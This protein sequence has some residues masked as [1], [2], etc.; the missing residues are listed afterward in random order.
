MLEN[1]PSLSPRER[2]DRVR[3]IRSQNVGP[4]TFRQLLERYGSASSALE[5]LPE[6]AR[7]GGLRKPLCLCSA[8]TAAREMDAVAQLGGQLIVIGEPDYP[9]PLAAIAD[10]PPVLSV[11]GDVNLLSRTTIGVVGARN[12]S[13]NGRRFA[14][15]LARDLSKAGVLV[16]SGLA[17]GIDTAV[18]TG[19]L[20]GGTVAVLAGGVD[21]IYPK[22]NTSLYEAIRDRGVIVSEMPPGTEPMARH[23]PSR[24]RIISGLSLGIVVVEAALRSGSLITARLAGEQGREV[25][26]IPGSPLDP[27]ARG[28]NNLIRNGAT[29]T[30]SAEDVLEGIRAMH[31]QQLGEPKQD[32]FGIQPVSDEDHLATARTMI[33]ECLGPTPV[34]I[35]AI[36]RDT[37]LPVGTV[38][39]VLLELELAGR[40]ERQP[41]GKVALLL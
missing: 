38:W 15:N 30:E 39:T 17:R 14:E 31:E 4:V 25:F 18:H 33:L 28:A 11:L 32:D 27:R 20:E 36:L 6:L 41:G 12:A 19:A 9:L 10:A 5:A 7:Q 24:N 37:G 34:S 1:S 2:L 13:T 26:A 16:A 8:D 22:E 21:V 3:L 40:L 23:F 35:D 29:L